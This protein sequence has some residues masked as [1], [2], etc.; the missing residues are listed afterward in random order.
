M[1]DSDWNEWILSNPFHWNDYISSS[2]LGFYKFS[3]FEIPQ[4]NFM[5]IVKAC[6]H[7]VFLVSNYCRYTFFG[8]FEF[9][10]FLTFRVPCKNWRF[11]PHLTWINYFSIL[12]MLIKTYDVVIM[13]I[14]ECLITILCV[15]QN[16]QTCCMVSNNSLVNI[17]EVASAVFCSVSMS[18]LELEIYWGSFSCTFIWYLSWF[19]NGSFPRL[20]SHKLISFIFLL[21]K[22]VHRFRSYFFILFK[23]WYSDLFNLFFI[24]NINVFDLFFLLSLILIRRRQ[25]RYF[26][27]L[28]FPQNDSSIITSNR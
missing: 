16:S 9:L 19:F 18:E 21:L 12:L 24:L 8:T 17:S 11:S 27:P 20:N 7:Y 4:I 15:H 5:I 14:E 28:D 3:C 25:F 1:L 23:F 22:V 26:R 13:C 2:F 6:C 10:Y